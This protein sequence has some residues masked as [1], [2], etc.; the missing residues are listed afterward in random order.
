MFLLILSTLTLADENVIYKK[1][2]EI[3]FEAVDVEGQLKKPNGV[4][5][6]E[7]D[8]AYFNPLVQIRQGWSIE[9]IGSIKDIQ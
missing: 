8:K 7:K 3:D 6:Q 9:M 2:T 4:F 5:I 1:R